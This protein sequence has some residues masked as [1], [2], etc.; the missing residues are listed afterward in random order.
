MSDQITIRNSI[1]KTWG[2]IS[3]SGLIISVIFFFALSYSGSPLWIGIFRL[4]AFIGFA[5]AVISYLQHREKTK[6]IT[7][8]VDE[9]QIIVQY[10]IA[11]RKEQEELFERDTVKT[12]KVKSAPAIWGFFPR[13][14]LRKF[15]ITFTD[16]KNT[17]SFFKFGGKNLFIS[18]DDAAT[19]QDFLGQYCTV[20]Q[21]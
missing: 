14:E 7:L 10:F 17:L 12:I 21:S 19:V 20:R 1:S 2:I 11:S 5:A 8:L 15:L 3:I 9:S 18:T 6:K 4:L 13:N 16:S